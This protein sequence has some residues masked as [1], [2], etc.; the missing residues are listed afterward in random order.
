MVPSGL[1][2]IPLTPGVSED[3]TFDCLNVI[4]AND[5]EDNIK[6]KNNINRNVLFI[7]KTLQ[8]RHC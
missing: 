5:L 7:I 1:K 3:I 4:K 8:R 6:N 2:F